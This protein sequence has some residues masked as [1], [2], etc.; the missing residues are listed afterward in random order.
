MERLNRKPSLTV[1]KEF[2]LPDGTAFQV[3]NVKAGAML[4]KKDKMSKE[5]A[6]GRL[7]AAKLRVRLP[8]EK[9]FKPICYEDLTDCFNDDE[10]KIICEN[11]V[12][13]E[14]EEDDEK[15]V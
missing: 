2:E 15:N 1:K 11:V 13:K 9:E 10:F 5:E 7:I 12:D 14:E 8:D 3:V 4:Q 6:G